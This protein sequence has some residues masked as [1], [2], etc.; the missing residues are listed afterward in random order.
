M[1]R[2]LGDRLNVSSFVHVDA[3]PERAVV[4]LRCL[5]DAEETRVH[6]LVVE[7]LR[8]EKGVRREHRLLR[9][10][11]PA[12]D[13]VGKLRSEGVIR[14]QHQV[15]VN[16]RVVVPAA[17]GVEQRDVQPVA[18]GERDVGGENVERPHA[19][20]V[21]G[22]QGEQVPALDRGALA[23]VQGHL[24]APNDDNRRPPT[25]AELGAPAAYPGAM[26]HLEGEVARLRARD[27]GV[28]QAT[29]KVEP[30][31]RVSPLEM[32]NPDRGRAGPRR[33][34]G[35][36]RRILEDLELVELGDVAADERTGDV[37]GRWCPDSH[38][39]LDRRLRDE[40]REE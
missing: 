25:D 8:P 27:D 12:R 39:E 9:A 17:L 34:G 2:E 29:A 22:E 6:A 14:E 1:G 19:H 37:E 4:G 26:T 31:W 38:P 18:I 5:R 32:G 40:A 36:L 10:I 13:D 20:V 24:P 3:R 15:A 33:E 21:A 23:L 35:Q 28:G 16:V 11:E 7:V 30:V